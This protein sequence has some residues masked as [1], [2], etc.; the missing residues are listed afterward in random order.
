METL[1]AKLVKLR[2]PWYGHMLCLDSGRILLSVSSL[3]EI[4]TS[5]ALHVLTTIVHH[6]KA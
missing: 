4:S 3:I 1:Q 5:F 6:Q 2:I